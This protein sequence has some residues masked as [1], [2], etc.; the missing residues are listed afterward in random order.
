MEPDIDGW[1]ETEIY[2]NLGFTGIYL[3]IQDDHGSY[4]EFIDLHDLEDDLEEGYEITE[5][6]PYDTKKR[7]FFWN[8]MRLKKSRNPNKVYVYERKMLSATKGQKLKIKDLSSSQMSIIDDMK[9][10]YDILFAILGPSHELFEWS[11]ITSWDSLSFEEKQIKYDKFISN[12][13]NLFL[14]FK[15]RDFFEGVVKPHMT[16]KGN[17]KL[18]DFFLLG[19]KEALKEYL[20]S[21]KLNDLTVLEKLLLVIALNQEES[22]K[23]TKLVEHSKLLLK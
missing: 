2:Q 15:D 1:I 18:I 12:E 22:K 5:N 8:D 3:I 6:E 4:I 21:Y 7:H 11:F 14:F 19:N 13:M 20:S 23:C 16:N 10:L 17:K 9:S